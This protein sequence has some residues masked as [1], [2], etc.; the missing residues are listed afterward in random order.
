[1]FFL[2]KPKDIVECMNSFPLEETAHFPWAF[3]PPRCIEQL[4]Y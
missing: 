1:M 2:N 3:A 4:N